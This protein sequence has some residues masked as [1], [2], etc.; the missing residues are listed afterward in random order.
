MRYNES[1][2]KKL[3]EIGYLK[4]VSINPQLCADVLFWEYSIPSYDKDRRPTLV[5]GK[6]M[7]SNR[8]VIDCDV[9]LFNKLNVRQKRVWL[10]ESAEQNSVCSMEFLPFVAHEATLNF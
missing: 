10:V 1:Q 2:I 7:H 9:L 6:T 3:K 4:T 5:L 8:F